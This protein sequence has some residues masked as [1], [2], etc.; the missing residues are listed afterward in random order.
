V[1]DLQA[2]FDQVS[3]NK[4]AG[5][6]VTI[7][8]GGRTLT[9][10]HV[11]KSQLLLLSGAHAHVCLTNGCLHLPRSWQL[12]VR[13]GASLKLIGVQVIS[14]VHP[15]LA[16]DT[17][18]WAERAGTKL[19]LEDCRI[20]RRKSA[21]QLMDIPALV[22]LAVVVESGAEAIFNRCLIEGTRAGIQVR[23]SGTSALLAACAVMHCGET[24]YYVE[25]AGVL[26]A[27]HCLALSNEGTGFKAW[28]EGTV[29]QLTDCR[30]EKNERHGL[31]AARDALVVLD[32]CVLLQ[33]GQND[34]RVEG[35]AKLELAGVIKPG[36]GDLHAA[37]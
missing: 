18:I 25:G 21:G 7:D 12:E 8:L 28:G 6:K 11:E 20:H 1:E 27:S 14:I 15:Y 17:V 19:Q 4:E 35:G 23:G 22:P 10:G 32:E 33:N 13:N 34:V 37:A 26:K 16:R 29:L 24:A 5:Q 31:H 30:S 36:G 3:G 2:V 9:G